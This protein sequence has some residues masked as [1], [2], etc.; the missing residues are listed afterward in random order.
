MSRDRPLLVEVTG[1]RTVD[2]WWVLE[3]FLKADFHAMYQGTH[4]MRWI[5]VMRQ[6]NTYSTK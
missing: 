1:Q 5:I 3:T 2:R 4:Y 6:L